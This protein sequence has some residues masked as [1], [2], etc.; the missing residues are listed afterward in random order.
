[1]AR[2]KVGD[3]DIVSIL[4]LEAPFPMA[5]VFPDVPADAFAPY[6]PLYPNAFHEADVKLGIS[7]FVIAGGGQAILVDTGLGPNVNPAAPGKLV[8]SLRAE[9]FAAEDIGT[10]LFTHLHPDHVGWNF[11]DGMPTFPNARYVVQQVDWD[12]FSTRKDEEVVQAQVLPLEKTG[13]LELVSGETQLTPQ[14]TLVPTPGHTPG[15]QSVIVA[16]GGTRAFIAGDVG[17]HPAQAQETAWRVGFDNDA[18]EASATRE[19]VM[20]QLERDGDNACF[21][22]FP[23]PGFG[24]IVREGGR[25]IFRAL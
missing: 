4:D 12:F 24:V 21:G 18:A 23:K 2:I 14:I 20:A 7:C 11:Q 25:R 16:S 19:R 15:H 5:G 17:H 9:G 10:V 6:R 8:E 1:M 3:L 13:R 22:H